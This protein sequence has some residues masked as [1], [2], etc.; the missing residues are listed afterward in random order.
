MALYAYRQGKYVAILDTYPRGLT[1]MVCADFL[2]ENFRAR[3]EAARSRAQ[4][5]APKGRRK[6]GEGKY[7]TSFEVTAGVA[8]SSKGHRRA[9]AKLANNSSYAIYVEWG[10][11]NIAPHRVLRRAV[12]QRDFS[13]DKFTPKGSRPRGKR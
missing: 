9:Y 1:D 11:N 2:V 12:G 8:P 5:I 4:A 13:G 6:R 7:A 3:A 10:N